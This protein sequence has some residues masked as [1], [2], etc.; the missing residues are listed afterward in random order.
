MK[1]K[2]GDEEE[3][4]EERMLLTGANVLHDA[5]DP[6]TCNKALG[7]IQTDEEK[8]KLEAMPSVSQLQAKKREAAKKTRSI[9]DKDAFSSY[10]FRALKQAC[11]ED[12]IQVGIS[13]TAMDTMNSII[14]EKFDEIM[15][16]GRMLVIN[17]KKSTLTSREVEA[18]VKLALSGELAKGAVGAGR[19]ALKEAS[20]KSED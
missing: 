17:S 2:L 6:R 4:K 11:A 5:P 13:Q 10:I 20:S 19:S 1:D 3:I 16:E 8:K 14:V 9:Y 7:S 18:C 15:S 12:G